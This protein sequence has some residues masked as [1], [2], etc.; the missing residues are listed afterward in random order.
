MQTK[1]IYGL[2][3]LCSLSAPSALA[4]EPGTNYCQAGVNST[5]VGAPMSA[6]GTADIL[7]NDLVLRA[8]F[9]PPN[10]PGLFF[11]G[12]G[13]DNAPLGNG[14]RCIHPAGVGLFRLSPPLSAGGGSL[15]W[16][17]DYAAQ[18]I[19]AGQITTG[20]TWYFQAWYRDPAAGG[21]SFN[22]TD[23]YAITFNCGGG[24]GL[25]AGMQAI[26]GGP[27]RMGDH[28]DEGTSDEDPLHLVI[29]SGFWMD[30]LEVTNSK[31]TAFLNCAMGRG[32]VR[33]NGDGVW[34]EGGAGEAL[35]HTHDSSQSSHIAWDATSNTFST[36]PGWEDHP[37][38]EVSWYGAC[39]YANS[40]SRAHGLTEAYDELTWDCDHATDG[41]RLP[42]EAEWEYAAR[43]GQHYRFS[44]G[45]AING[46]H[47][48]YQSSGDPFEAR[49][50][51]TTPVGY[52]NGNQVPSGTD[53]ANGYGLYDMNGNVD[54]LCGDWFDFGYYASSPIVNPTGPVGPV[55]TARRVIRGG[56][57]SDTTHTFYLRTSDRAW[58]YPYYMHG[59]L[60]FR[61]VAR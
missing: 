47:A 21:A 58:A 40:L 25:H 10:R 28:H 18:S 22:L 16:A 15:E 43:G 17:V 27:F 34:Q 37:A 46:S 60:G 8:E 24:E 35:C 54:E 57:F 45:E 38:V 51:A 9:L 44:W 31:Y 1:P 55:G 6:S 53:T 23:G 7:R 49:S 3:L 32:E 36:L 56:S 39:L 13:E 20:S 5:G 41:Y 26:P 33:K 59:A 52:Y 11:Y 4:G 48:N 42:T 12:A 14:F 19:V 30:T 50:P 29:L 61:L 2:L